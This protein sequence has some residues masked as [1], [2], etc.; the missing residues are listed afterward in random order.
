MPTN[1]YIMRDQSRFYPRERA[2][3]PKNRFHFRQL[4]RRL[5][6]VGAF[7]LA[8]ASYLAALALIA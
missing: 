3:S 2:L 8:L 5:L 7:L 4:A 6:E 1:A